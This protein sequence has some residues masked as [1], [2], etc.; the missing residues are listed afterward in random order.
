[1][2]HEWEILIKDKYKEKAHFI[3]T[4]KLFVIIL[5]FPQC[6]DNNKAYYSQFGH[7][8]QLWFVP[9]KR[10]SLD[11]RQVEETMPVSVS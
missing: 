6:L 7:V 8:I 5:S 11:M 10:C 4:H 2:L 9:R 3:S 1:M